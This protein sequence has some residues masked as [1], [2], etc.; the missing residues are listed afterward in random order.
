MVN[1]SSTGKTR[2]R[3]PSNWAA[4]YS[5]LLQFA[6]RE[7]HSTLRSRHVEVVDGEE[8]P[9]GEWV[10]TQRRTY[11]AGQLNREQEEMLE[12]ITGWEWEPEHTYKS[13][14]QTYAAG[15]LRQFAK[16]EGHSNVPSG[17]L[18]VVDGEKFRLGQWVANRRSE[19]RRNQISSDRIAEL[20]AIP[21]WEWTG[22][23][24]TRP[25]TKRTRPVIGM[26]I[27]GPQYWLESPNSTTPSALEEVGAYLLQRLPAP[28][29]NGRLFDDE[30]VEAIVR[31]LGLD[32]APPA[33]LQEAGD[34]I[35]VTRERV[36]QQ[37]AKLLSRIKHARHRELTPPL[38]IFRQACHI[39][40]DPADGDLGQRLLDQGLTSSTYWDRRH[41]LC[42]AQLGGNRAV[43]AELESAISVLDQQEGG[44]E[45]LNGLL[46]KAVWKASKLSGFCLTSTCIEQLTAMWQA[47]ADFTPVPEKDIIRE[48]ISKHP[49]VLELPMEYLYATGTKKLMAP[50]TIGGGQGKRAISLTL[51]ML[52]VSSPLHL[53]DIREGLIRYSRFKHVPT[54][55]PSSV[56]RAFFNWHSEFQ[57]D[58]DGY[59]SVTRDLDSPE[60]LIGWLIQEMRASDY[61]FLTYSQAVERGRR[62]RKN[63]SSLSIFLTYA[64]EVRKNRS[65][66]Y[67][68]VGEP[69]AEHLILQGLSAQKLAAIKGDQEF[70]FDETKRCITWNLEIGHSYLNG[71]IGVPSRDRVYLTLLGERRFEIVDSSGESHGNL[72]VSAAMQAIRGLSVY[73]AHKFIEPGDEVT[74]IIDLEAGVARADL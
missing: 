27:T 30:W 51:K 28:G 44:R 40:L 22:T 46:P 70:S 32:G 66:C 62:A 49:L 42:L 45:R 24:L 50:V 43:A 29:G 23:E 73:F 64:P 11:R 25:V 1:A 52:A 41:L 60:G 61:G 67:Y 14:K 33:T 26:K 56:L 57:V 54:N 37:Q 74:L 5:A 3:K 15:V 69:P 12:A 6:D 7:G 63:T 59:V 36:R 17:H 68:P 38:L 8:F 65:G 71:T 18:E 48:A 21:G 47:E 53:S 10:R 34:I 35:G 31:R 55:L 9:I 4:S 72:S 58:P 19:Y 39:A 2:K 20:E 16:R 13:N